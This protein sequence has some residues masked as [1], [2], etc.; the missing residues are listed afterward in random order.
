M[1]EDSRIYELLTQPGFSRDGTVLDR[2]NYVDGQWV[3]FQRGRPRKMGGFKEINGDL[4]SIQRGGFVFFQDGIV[5]LYGFGRNKCQVVKT[6]QD[7]STGVDTTVVLPDLT[8]DDIYTFQTDAIFDALGSSVTQILIHG[9]KNVLDIAD[10]TETPVFFTVIGLDPPDFVK[11]QDGNGNDVL[12]SGGVVVLQPFVF[13]Y[14]NDGL[15]KN[16]NQNNPN[17]FRTDQGGAANA[18][19]VA[20][21]KIVKGLPLRGGG[22]SPAGLF[23][24]LDSLIRVSYAS[25]SNFRYDTI[26]SQTSIL[27]PSG[28]IEYDGAYFWVGVDRFLV[29]DGAVREVPN[30]QNLNWFFDN[31]NYSARTKV[32]ATKIPRFGEIWWFFP[33]GSATEC[34]HAIILNVREKVWYDVELARSAGF[35]SQVFKYPVMYG[36]EQNQGGQYSIFAHEFGRDAIY[37]SEQHAISAHVETSGIDFFDGTMTGGEGNHENVWTCLD[38]VEPDFVLSGNLNMF[39]RGNAFAQSSVTEVGPYEITPSTEKVDTRVQLR[40]MR[41]K[42]VSNESEGFFEQGKVILH[43][44]RGDKRS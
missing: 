40:N 6:T 19:N 42:F 44:R 30:Q 11:I 18:V 36:N 31:I 29:Y 7:A 14:G 24:S 37:D 27:S 1:P 15:I 21:T 2:N 25:G 38:R 8:D 23:W 34:T 32:W 20:A 17:D 5:Y 33:F 35:Q 13:V 39:V 4:S 26:S 22:A 43:I 9:A 16:S 3:R 41:L 12:V 28:V 10:R